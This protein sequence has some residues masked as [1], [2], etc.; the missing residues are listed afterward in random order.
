MERWQQDFDFYLAQLDDQPA[1]FVFD[2]NAVAHAPVA[3]HPL[4]VRITVPMLRPRPDGLRD[5]SELDDLAALEDQFVD[6]LEAKVDAIY[7]GRVVHA[8]ATTLYLY[9]PES[10]RA[11]VEELPALTGDP[12]GDY[13]PTWT[14]DDDPTWRLHG[15]LEPDPYARQGIW[16][17]RLIGVFAQ[18]GDLGIEPREIDHLAYFPTEAAAEAARVALTALGFRCD[19]LT[20]DD[21]DDG[22]LWT[23]EF[24]REDVLSGDR[25]DAFVSQ[26]LDVILPLDGTYDGWGAEQRP[27]AG[28]G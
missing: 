24:H 11:A 20:G 2:L 19:D 27:T 8:G 4:A 18:H 23:V 16:N 12:P 1:S 25:P 28:I 13:A 14:L 21:A 7:V 17:R 6:A 10:H 9:V 5:A 26:F 15:F 3:S 22:G